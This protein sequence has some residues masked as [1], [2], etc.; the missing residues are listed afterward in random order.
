MISQHGRPDDGTDSTGFFN[1]EFFVPLRP[2]E[3]WRKGLDK[4][5]L[6]AEINDALAKAFPGVEFTFSQYI[7]DNVQEAASGVKGE[8]SVKVYGPDLETLRKV[9]D[10]IKN[11]IA[12]VP[13]ITDLAVS[14]SLGQPTIRIDIDRAKAA[15]YGL[16][17][18]DINATVQAAIGG[19]AAGDVYENGSD[20]HFPM[21]V[22]L[23][24]ALP[25]EYRGDQAHPDRRAGQ[26]AA[27]TQVP[28]AELAKVELVSGAYYIYREQQERYVPVK[29]S[30]RGRDLGGAILEAQERVA[31][32]V[33]TP[34]R[35]SASNGS[36]S[37]AT[38]RTPCSGWRSPCRSP[39]RL[40]LLLLYISF[41]SL[42]DTLLAGS[43]IPMAL[44][45]GV[46]GA[47][48]GRHAVQHLGRHRLRRPVRH[49][50]H[51]RH[52]GA[53]GCYNRLIEPDGRREA[54]LRRDLHAADAA[55]ADDLR[56]RLASACCRAAFSTGDRQP[57][58]A[59]AGYRRGRRHAA[60]ALLFLT[61]L[62]AAIGLFSRRT[63]RRAVRRPAWRRRT[64]G[65]RTG[66]P[67]VLLWRR[68]SAA[69]W[70][71]RTSRRPSRRRPIAICPT[72]AAR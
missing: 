44:V 13:G 70:S 8:N 65:P 38:S 55:G 58:A 41:G 43:A 10:E 3:Q 42:R 27:S 5:A 50:R 24:A 31:E 39:S 9:A 62:P 30:V 40:I 16:A 21:I 11:A 32:K 68:R 71:A 12:T 35:L 37:S 15:R 34:G 14:A 23:G 48:R 28:L 6:I 64:D 52:H 49:R 59:A 33:R 36:A 66:L 18:G 54:A 61:V 25:R 1:A 20:R 19:Q 60:G 63:A 57:G 22:R 47:V 53:V 67:P 2:F 45:G 29:F 4:D 51:E 26:Q 56:R 72:K 46:A 7:Q 69:A 17:P